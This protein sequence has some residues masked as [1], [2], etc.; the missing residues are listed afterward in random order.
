MLIV[1]VV[2]SNEFKKKKGLANCMTLSCSNCEWTYSTY[3]SRSIEKPPVPG[4]NAFDINVRSVITFREIGKGITAMQALCGYTNLV[5]PMQAVAYNNNQKEV[6]ESYRTVANSSM[7]KAADDLNQ[8]SSNIAVS[9][10]GS[11]QQRGSS[12]L[13]G[14]VTVDSRKCLDFRVKGKKCTACSSWESG[15][16]TDEYIDFA[17]NHEC[18]IN[19]EGSSGSMESDALV[20]IFKASETFNQ[21]RYVEFLRDGDTKSHHDV[22]VADPYPGTIFKKLECIGHVQKRVG[23]RLRKLKASYK[24]TK[25]NKKEDDKAMAKLTQTN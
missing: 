21:L 12:S 13:N 10:D 5:P 16:G 19:H 20:E 22:V 18:L 7:L 25:D 6:A 9:C 4:I 17:S 3:T 2:I 11:W 24:G 15:K 8:T 23:S 1:V 14:L